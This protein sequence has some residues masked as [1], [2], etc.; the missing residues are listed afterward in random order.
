[1]V[2]LFCNSVFAGDVFED[3]YF[4]IDPHVIG[5]KEV[6]VGGSMQRIGDL[7]AEELLDAREYLETSYQIDPES[8]PGSDEG[9]RKM[10]R[11]LRYAIGPNKEPNQAIR[12]P[13]QVLIVT[14]VDIHWDHTTGNH[15][16]FADISHEQSLWREWAQREAMIYSDNV[17]KM[18][19]GRIR[20]VPDVRVSNRPIMDI[21]TY[22][23]GRQV[24]K[25]KDL[26]TQIKDAF[27]NKYAPWKIIWLPKD[28]TGTQP[29]YIGRAWTSYTGELNGF[30]FVVMP[31]SRQRLSEPG[32]WGGLF[33]AGLV[34]EGWHVIRQLSMRKL[35]FPG[36]IPDNHS[37]AHRDLMLAEMEGQDLPLPDLYYFDYYSMFPTGRMARHMCKT[38]NSLISADISDNSHTWGISD[39][40]LPV[41][42][43]L[44][45]GRLDT[46]FSTDGEHSTSTK[47]S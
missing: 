3:P 44:T 34:H 46:S 33:A 41:A 18:S 19:W 45:D 9:I 26:K 12:I 39:A 14:T 4:H 7:N 15:S 17:Y 28:G 5:A 40:G 20:L 22:S 43:F 42:S 32:R 10:L 25:Y 38:P 37:S 29:H 27:A 13:M 2:G 35:S 6:W 36:F 8:V 31:T 1:V 16:F 11:F 30:S 21:T 24:Y 47:S 23:S